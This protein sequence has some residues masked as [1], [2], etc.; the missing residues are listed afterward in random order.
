[1]ASPFTHKSKAVRARRTKRVTL[2]AIKLLAR[3]FHV[4]APIAYNGPWEKTKYK[5]PPEWAFWANYDL[6]FLRRCDALIVFKIYGW[7][8]S[9]GM[10]AE[11][12][13]AKSIG[14][15]VFYV[16]EKEIEDGVLPKKLDEFHT[17]AKTHDQ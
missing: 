1:M 8:K 5:L 4:F 16:T 3:D 15:P 7:R 10:Q 2:A 13:Y 12:E 6:N 11:I 9:V 14:M 17:K